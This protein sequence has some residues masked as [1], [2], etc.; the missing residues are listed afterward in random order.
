MLNLSFS[1]IFVL[2]K[3][4]HYRDITWHWQGV[5]RFIVILMWHRQCY[6]FNYRKNYRCPSYDFFRS[7]NHHCSFHHYPSFDHYRQL[8]FTDLWS[9]PLPLPFLGPN[10]DN[11]NG[12]RKV[13]VNS[14][15]Q[16]NNKNKRING[17]KKCN[18]D[19]VSRLR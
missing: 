13:N 14:K 10:N 9:L 16:K 3:T 11:G 1:E 6:R 19:F 2:F 18:G 4:L 8:T 15:G 12:K 7:F 17:P 5:S